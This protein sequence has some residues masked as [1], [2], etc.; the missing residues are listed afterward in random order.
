VASGQQLSNFTI[1][2]HCGP[3]HAASPLHIDPHELI[4]Q[5]SEVVI[6]RVFKSFLVASVLAV[7][8]GLSAQAADIDAPIASEADPLI[9]IY[10]RSDIGGA[11]LSNSGATDDKGYVMGGGVGYRFNDSFRSDVTV[12]WA[13]RYDLGAGSVSTTTVLGNA[14]LDLNNDTAFTPYIGAG[15][16]YSFVDG[17]KDGA[18]LAGRAGV[19]IDLTQNIAVDVGYKYQHTLIKSSADL[20]EHQAMI[21]LRFGF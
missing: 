1:L 15:A 18:A 4:N 17:G 6:M 3:H 10:L 16:G 21:G 7:P 9:G 11:M 5:K 19:A 14:Y 2:T 13:G 20:K 8:F 12:D